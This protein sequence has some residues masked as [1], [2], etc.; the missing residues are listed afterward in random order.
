M[1]MVRGLPYS[2]LVHLMMLA[3]VFFY[4]NAVHRKP[5]NPPRSIKVRMVQLPAQPAPEPVAAEVEP[6]PT[7]PAPK[8]EEK[9]PELPPKAV[10]ETKPEP[11][12]KPVAKEPVKEKDPDPPRPRE[13]T[14]PAE[15]SANQESAAEP[16]PVVSGPAVAGTDVDFPFAWYLSLVQG[17]IASNWHPK[18][19]GFR[20]RTV[21][22]CLVHF[23]INKNGSVSQVTLTR[24]SGV[25]V[26]DREALRVVQSS[27]IPPLPP[28][29]T[30]NSLGVSMEFNLESGI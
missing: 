9:A 29:F 13:D 16:T 19:L 2:I 30:A 28:G 22:S 21:V 12:P 10:P 23:T 20:S 8:V 15:P 18:Q 6:D 27:G 26:F 24:S 11:E 7:P 17:K 4:G 5:I 3:L 25:G 1:T 14:P